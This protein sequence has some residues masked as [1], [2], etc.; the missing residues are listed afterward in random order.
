MDSKWDELERWVEG[1]KLPKGFDVLREP[2]WVEQFVRK[3]MTKALPEAAGAIAEQASPYSF[4]QSEQFI[5]VKFPLPAH[6]RSEELRLWVKEDRLRVEGL[7]GNR[8]ELIK[9]PVGVRPRVCRAIVKDGELRVK[10]RKRPVGR[11]YYEADIRW[12]E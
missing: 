3:M 5:I 11:K 4:S 9:L 2:D 8:K 7:P 10:L 6:V 1:Q 12:Q